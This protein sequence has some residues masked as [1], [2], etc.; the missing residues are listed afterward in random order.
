MYLKGL[1][2]TYGNLVMKSV[3]YAYR[4]FGLNVL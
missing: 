3:E 2:V 4:V 1:F